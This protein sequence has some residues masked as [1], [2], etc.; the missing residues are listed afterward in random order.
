MPPRPA[1]LRMPPPAGREN[2]AEIRGIH[3]LDALV[4]DV[5]T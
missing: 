5:Y 2:D 1:R 4:P 3:G